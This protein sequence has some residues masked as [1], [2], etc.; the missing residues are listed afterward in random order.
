M[1]GSFNKNISGG[2]LRKNVATFTDEV[3]LDDGQFKNVDG[4]VKNLNNLRI[5]GYGYVNGEYI[6]ADSCDYQLVGLTEG[7]CVSWGNPMGEMYL[8]ALRY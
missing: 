8:E 5:Y 2:V 3:D 7:N 4:I 6:T 1:T